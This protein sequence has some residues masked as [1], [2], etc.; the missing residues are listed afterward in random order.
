M[1]VLGIGVL[2]FTVG[3]YLIVPYNI[4]LCLTIIALQFQFP[5]QCAGVQIG[6]L[7]YGIYL[8]HPLIAFCING[9]IGDQ[10]R[11]SGSQALLCQPWWFLMR[12]T[13]LRRVV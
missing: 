10:C 8:I 3:N 12:L 13:F 5:F 11:A 1:F 4:G 9:V 6:Q 2:Y 7:T